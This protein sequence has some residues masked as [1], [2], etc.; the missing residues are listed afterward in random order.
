[1]EIERPRYKNKRKPSNVRK[2]DFEI[3]KKALDAINYLAYLSDKLTSDQHE[4]VF[5]EH[6][7]EPLLESIFL[8]YVKQRENKTVLDNRLFRLSIITANRALRCA[9]TMVDVGVFMRAKS[10][11]LIF[12]SEDELRLLTYH[13]YNTKPDAK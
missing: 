4:Q 2:R 7:L 5:N 13:F 10:A 1:M 9:K 3:R 11:P 12:P 8:K 6:T